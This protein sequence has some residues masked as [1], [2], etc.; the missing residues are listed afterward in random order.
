[1]GTRHQEPWCYDEELTDIYRKAVNFRYRIIP[2]IYDLFYEAEKTGIPVFRPLVLEYEDD[3]NTFE[4]NDELM[5]G[6]Y[7]IASPVTTEGTKKKYI[8]QGVIGIIISQRKN[9]VVDIIL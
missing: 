7:L 9:I 8:Y 5:L 2:Y 6:E 1:M 3:I 4:L